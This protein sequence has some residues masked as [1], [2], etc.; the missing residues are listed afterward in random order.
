MQ[1][2]PP[3]GR[4]PWCFWVRK[5]TEGLKDESLLKKKLF[6]PVFIIRQVPCA[7]GHACN[8]FDFIV[9]NFCVHL[10]V[11]IGAGRNKSPINSLANY[12]KW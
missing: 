11:R 10:N 4:A 1:Q 7:L 3:Q 5:A 9:G 2:R 6:S 8:S 12:Q